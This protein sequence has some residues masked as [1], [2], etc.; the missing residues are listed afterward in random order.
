MEGIRKSQKYRIIVVSLIAV[1]LLGLVAGV[2]VGLHQNILAH[3]PASNGS[4][5]KVQEKATEYNEI[6]VEEKAAVNFGCTRTSRWD[7]A[8]QYDRALSLIQQRLIEGTRSN[9]VAEVTDAF[10][11]FPPDLVN[12]IVIKEKDLK[13]TDGV[14]GYFSFDDPSLKSNY[15]PINVSR[16]Y[17]ET[18][19]IATALLI[20]HE[21]T[22]VQQ[23]RE[24]LKGK[25]TDCIDSEVEAFLAQWDFFGELNIEEITS[26]NARI[27][28]GSDSYLHSQLQML[29]DIRE[30]NT[31]Y[32]LPA[33]GFLEPVCSREVLRVRLRPLIE[34][35]EYY[36]KQCGLE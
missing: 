16:A 28:Y 18:D 10:I 9:K 13:D 21:M 23:Y 19:D 12:C 32:A 11:A 17:K 31:E 25:D 5:I 2:R 15:F 1:A 34:E 24:T 36:R 3:K 29:Q 35:N 20:V 26:I 7:N 30:L 22:H 4:E 6:E 27:N 14:E 8:P 33:C